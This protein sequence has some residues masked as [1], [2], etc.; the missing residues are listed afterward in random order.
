MHALHC[1]YRSLKSLNQGKNNKI[2]TEMTDESLVN[3][4]AF[5]D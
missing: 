4:V 3:L 1:K 2:N 5:R